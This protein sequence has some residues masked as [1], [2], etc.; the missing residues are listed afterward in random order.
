MITFTT[1]LP[2]TE[3]LYAY[4]NNVVEFESDSTKT[5]IRAII[6]VSGEV[7]EITP[8]TSGAFHYN[9][10]MLATKLLNDNYF[11]DT[12][13]P[14]SESD[15]VYLDDTVYKELAVTFVIEFDDQTQDTITN[16]Y[17]FLKAVEQLDQYRIGLSNTDN[18]KVAIL[19]PFTTRCR[20]PVSY[21]HLTLPTKRIV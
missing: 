18:P 7:L 14:E 9:F 17:K 19:T 4:N 3:L 2:T 16:T 21:T 5:A 20:N 6:N 1:A 11:R 13:D 10:K 12:I 15:I 8:N